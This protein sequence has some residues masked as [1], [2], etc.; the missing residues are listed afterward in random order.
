METKDGKTEHLIFILIYDQEQLHLHV[1]RIRGCKVHNRNTSYKFI[2]HF[3]HEQ[4]IQ[5]ALRGD[6]CFEIF[7]HKFQKLNELDEM[8]EVDQ[9]FVI[10]AKHEIELVYP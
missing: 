1:D 2:N 7:Y 3:V 8:Q 10:N 5:L 6:K 4:K 9:Y